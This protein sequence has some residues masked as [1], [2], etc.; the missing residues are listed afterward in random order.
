MKISFSGLK[1]IIIGA[2]SITAITQFIRSTFDLTSQIQQAKIAFTN[3][4][5]SEEVA[6]KL[7][8]DIQSFAKQTPFDQFGLIDGAKRLSAY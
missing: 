6:L 5:K 4:F 1:E 3:L 2:F 8:K 7:I